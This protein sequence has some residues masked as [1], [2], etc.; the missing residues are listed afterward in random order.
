M[1]VF[2][3]LLLG[4]L[5]TFAASPTVAKGQG[6]GSPSA[7]ILI[8]LYSDFEC[9]ACRAFHTDLLPQLTREFISTGKVYLVDHDLCFHNYS[10]E[11]TGYALAAARIGK[12]PEVA[13]ALFQHQQEWATNGKV[14]DVVAGVLNA[15]D[16]KKVQTLAKDPGVLAEVKAETDDGRTKIQQ[17][18]TIIVMHSMR[19]YRFVGPN[20]ELLRGFLN[21]LLSK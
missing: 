6:S 8:E 7:P 9:P 15:A 20:W 18:P 3:L 17:T 16:Q 13:N 5:P 12:Y 10:A 2:A 1:K 14:W 19:Q 21:D 4:M 11:A